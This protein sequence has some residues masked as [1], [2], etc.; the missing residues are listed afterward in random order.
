MYVTYRNLMLRK[1]GAVRNVNHYIIT[2]VL[3]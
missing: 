3:I 1:E 2:N